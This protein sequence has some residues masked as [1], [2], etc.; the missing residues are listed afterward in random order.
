MQGHA[1]EIGLRVPLEIA[2]NHMATAILEMAAW[3]LENDMPYPPEEMGNF[4]ERLIIQATWQAVFPQGS[5]NEVHVS[6]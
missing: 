2:I 4:Y 5:G 1:T 3:W 6:D